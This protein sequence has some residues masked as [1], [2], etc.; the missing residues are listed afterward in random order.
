MAG[1]ATPSP[2][3]PRKRVTRK[4]A[5]NR[6]LLALLILI[7]LFFLVRR[8][9][10]NYI[11]SQRAT[12]KQTAGKETT[13]ISTT[14]MSEEMAAVTTTAV[15]LTEQTTVTTTTTGTPSSGEYLI[16][17]TLPRSYS[18][19]VDPVLQNPELP[20]GCEVTTLTMLL[21]SLGFD[22][23]KIQ[24]VEGYLTCKDPGTATPREAFIG[25]PYDGGGYG[26]YASVIIDTARK[27]LSAQ[28]SGRI[29]KDLSNSDFNTLLRE[30]ASN[31]AV[32]VWGSIGLVDI[33]EVY[34]YTITKADGETQ[35]VQWLENEHCFLLKGYDLDRDVV[36]V[37]DPL[38]GEM[39]YPMSRFEEVY[40]QC[41]KQALIIY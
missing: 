3:R 19:E 23:D 37:N 31:H 38:N 39:E 13:T 20:T 29:V 7:G 33:N 32:A 30:V 40:E 24:L 14:T 15:S 18:I 28:N 22:V 4:Q 21:Q 34:A 12:D 36:I 11:Q 10:A 17:G 16:S 8:G 6:R 1:T 25:T 2:Q 27:Y 41:Y 35:D 26:C 5:R 9:I